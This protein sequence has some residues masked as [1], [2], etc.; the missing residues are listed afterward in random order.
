MKVFLRFLIVLKR[1][2]PGVSLVYT[3]CFLICRQY[4]SATLTLVKGNICR[5]FSLLRKRSSW[6]Q[7]A[8][9][10]VTSFSPL[11]LVKVVPLY[12][13]ESSLCHRETGERRKKGRRPADV[14]RVSFPGSYPF[15]F[16]RTTKATR[17]RKPGEPR[18]SEE[19][20][21]PLEIEIDPR[22][23]GKRS[24]RTGNHNVFMGSCSCV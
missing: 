2:N 7:P 1:Y 20:E 24:E 10:T 11:I 16:R 12:S 5:T 22:E 8:W 6:T 17:T 13:N 19:G 18:D 3:P 21:K 23:P 14:L 9:L 4:S 15:I